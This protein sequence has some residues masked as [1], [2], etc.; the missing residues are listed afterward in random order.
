MVGHFVIFITRIRV[1]NERERSVLVSR[2]NVS[3]RY[4]SLHILCR[5]HRFPTYHTLHC[6]LFN[7]EPHRPAVFTPKILL[8]ACHL[9]AIIRVTGEPETPLEGS[10]QR[11]NREGRVEVERRFIV[12]FIDCSLRFVKCTLRQVSSDKSCRCCFLARQSESRASRR[13][14]D[15]DVTFCDSRT[16]T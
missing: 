9:D 13:L 7:V 10:L 4:S 2:Y 5:D 11:R 16:R 3:M 12:T 1:K 14:F 15:L 8:V 6:S